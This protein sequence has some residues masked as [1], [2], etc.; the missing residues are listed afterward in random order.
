[1]FVD[2]QPI[3]D[4]L[5]NVDWPWDALLVL[6]GAGFVVSLIFGWSEAAGLF[7]GTL[8]AAALILRFPPVVAGTEP[9]AGF[10]RGLRP[11]ILPVVIVLIAG[12]VAYSWLV[13][14]LVVPLLLVAAWFLL[15]AP[16]LTRTGEAFRETAQWL[17]K[18]LGDWGHIAVGLLILLG[19]GAIVVVVIGLTPDVGLY[20]DR[21][22]ISNALITI[23]LVAWMAAAVLRL[24]GFA[25]SW[26]RA[27]VALISVLAVVRVLMA[28]G[29]VPGH[30]WLIR[31]ADWLTAGHLLL[32]TAVG[33]GVI[34]VGDAIISLIPRLR[35]LESWGAFPVPLGGILRGL[36]FAAA[37][38][39]TVA[40]G[41]AAFYGVISSEANGR[42][43]ITPSDEVI[44]GKIVSPKR[45][46]LPEL[47]QKYQPVLVMTDAERWAPVSVDSYLQDQQHPAYLITPNGTRKPAPALADLPGVNGCH[48]G[49]A[50]CFRITIDCPSGSDDCAEG[51]PDR[52]DQGERIPDYRDGAVYVR[53]LSHRRPG[54]SPQAFNGTGPYGKNLKTL[55]QYWY[56]YR[57]DEW[58]RPILGGRIVQR[59]E[60][61]WEAVTIGFSQKAPLFAGLSA[62][63]GGSWLPWN[64]VQLAPTA[65]GPRVH[66]LIAVAEGSHA[67]YTRT[68]DRRA[69]DW[70]GCKGSVPQGT[71][72]VL[73]YASNIRDETSYG[74]DWL[75]AQ[76]FFV[77]NAK[78]PMTF[79][80]TWGGNDFTELINERDQRL[81]DAGPGPATPTLQPLWYDPVDQIFCSK[82]W[83]GPEP[84]G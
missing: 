12:T 56:F 16:E 21:P 45:T 66:P 19:I 15:V 61:D 8:F 22:E 69:P 26:F 44:A 41:A 81:S 63:C 59:H 3:R 52:T 57:Y 84:C 9:L 82:H 74:W 30:N 4:W 71:T 50:P 73:S 17:Q 24:G 23:A 78:P 51:Q 1:V 13:P 76:T 68:Q 64:K 31:H 6:L 28:A 29:L 80:G 35:F 34:V 14:L 53:V 79:P 62:H 75:P 11:L 39:A 18:G 83:H 67:N 10:L 7:I 58:T 65:K 38:L 42:D 60:G 20:E 70:A 40:L 5:R 43:G 72:T 2:L 49:R 77:N 36:G 54:G 27:V 48:G 46:P 37:G 32:L 25:T 33:L 55:I 47:A